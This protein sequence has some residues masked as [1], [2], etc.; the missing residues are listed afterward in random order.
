MDEPGERASH[1]T[2]IPN[3]GGIAIFSGTIFSIIMWTPFAVFSS[4]Q[5]ILCAMIIMFL[6]GAKDDIIPLTPAKK[7]GGEIIASF[8]LVFS[9]G[10]QLTSMHGLFGVHEIPP[11]VSIPLTT[12]T[13]LVIINAVN[14]IDGINGLAG[15][16]GA[17]ICTVFGYWFFKINALELAVI[18]TALCGAIVAFLRYN[19]ASKIFMGDTGSLLIGLVVSTLAIKFID[20]NQPAYINSHPEFRTDWIIGSAPAVA[21]GILIIPL[22]DTLR[23]FTMR[24]VRGKSPFHPDRNHIHHLLLDSGCTHLQA[25]V[26][27]CVVNL[28]FIVLVYKL[29]HIG[30]FELMVLLLTLALALTAPLYWFA[31]RARSMRKA[32]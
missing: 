25:T 8:I 9:A 7:F 30:A 32:A 23:V 27:L 10:V 18:A 29:Q 2:K 22:F 12:F 28:C 6:V 21:M 24:I 3:L 20:F 16:V 17:I 31:C 5:Y 4:L 19:V 14:L 11:L 15:G 26:T 13:I 1:T